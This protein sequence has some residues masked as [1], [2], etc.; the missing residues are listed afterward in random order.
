MKKI[1]LGASGWLKQPVSCDD[2]VYHEGKPI[3]TI[4]GLPSQ[5]IDGLVSRCASDLGLIVDWYFIAGRAIVKLFSSNF[6][7]DLNKIHKWM[8]L[9]CNLRIKAE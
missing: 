1:N 9:N 4:T 2:R 5:A 8:E 6:D 3:Y 7:T